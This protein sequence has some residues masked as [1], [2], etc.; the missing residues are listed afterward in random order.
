MREEARRGLW[1][2]E[3]VPEFFSMLKKKKEQAA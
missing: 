1:D 2:P 3:L